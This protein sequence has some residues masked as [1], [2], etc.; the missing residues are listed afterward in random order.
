ML[1]LD[2][3]ITAFAYAAIGLRGA[4]PQLIAAGVIETAPAPKKNRSS[5]AEDD[6]R[7]F[8]F[9]RRSLV[10]IIETHVPVLAAIEAASGSK[11]AKVAKHLGA[12]QA[13]AACVVDEALGDGRA[14]YVTALEAGDAAGIQRTQRT[15]RSKGEPKPKGESDLKRKMRKRAIARAVVERFGVDQWARAL[16]IEYGPA[17]DWLYLESLVLSE[18]WEGAHDAA[19]V[20]LAAWDHPTTAAIRMMA[21]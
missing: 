11:S 7:R 5:V 3:S 2:P 6:A 9:I 16:G 21:A 8:R 13:L 20:A 19:A 17:C 12:A 18:R 10:E 4:L 14:I 1:A 15:T